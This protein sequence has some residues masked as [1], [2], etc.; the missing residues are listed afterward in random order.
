MKQVKP[1]SKI[2]LKKKI[3]N[4]GG[5]PLE[6]YG[7]SENIKDYT[8]AEISEMKIGIYKDK[9]F[10]LVDGDYFVDVTKVVA[11]K[12]ELEKVTYRNKPSIEDYESN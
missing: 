1:I 3:L 2:N 9:K 7:R 12:C 8:K 10:L 6:K 11:S 4:V 5:L